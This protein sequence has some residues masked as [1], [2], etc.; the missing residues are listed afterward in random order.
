MRSSNMRFQLAGGGKGERPAVPGRARIVLVN[1]PLPAASS[2]RQATGSYRAIPDTGRAKKFRL[3]Y[4]RNSTAS[5][6]AVFCLD[7]AAY[8]ARLGRVCVNNDPNRFVRVIRECEQIGV[9]G[10]YLSL[11]GNA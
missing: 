8:L 3:E 6:G 1:M 5:T 7:S 4:S 9:F 10:R 11:G 2:S